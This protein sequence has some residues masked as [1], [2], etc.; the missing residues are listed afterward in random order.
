MSEFEYKVGYH[1]KANSDLIIGEESRSF[2][3][4]K[5]QNALWDRRLEEFF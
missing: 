3:A 1:T 2:I 4:D 5:E